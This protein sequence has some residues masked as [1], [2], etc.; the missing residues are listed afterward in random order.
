MKLMGRHPELSDLS[1]GTSDSIVGQAKHCLGCMIA[2]TRL[3][4]R[5]MCNHTL[6]KPA[7][8]AGE[9]YHTDVA[10]PSRPLGIGQAKFVLPVV[11]EY[12]RYLH[13]I[14]MRRKSQ[15]ASLLAQLF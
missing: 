3:E 6:A 14:P 1:L 5:A 9:S 15:A 7:E 13:V 4:A 10:G 2:N 11:D 8:A 12:T